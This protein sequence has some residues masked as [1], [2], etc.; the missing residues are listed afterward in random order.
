E[1]LGHPG[2]SVRAWTVRLLGDA[3]AVSPPL[4]KRLAELAVSDPS[5]VVVAQ[6]ACTAKRLPGEQALPII[7]RLLPR[8]PDGAVI[9]W[10]R[11]GARPRPGSRRRGRPEDAAA[12]APRRARRAGAVRRRGECRGRAAAA[13][14]HRPRRGDPGAGHPRPGRRSRRR[15]RDPGGVPVAPGG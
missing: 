15:R 13:E 4:A 7:E 11:R 1:L 12:A 14:V 6:L 3:K 5:P 2:E 8:G 10:R 9:P